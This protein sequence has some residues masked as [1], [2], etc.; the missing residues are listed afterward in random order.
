MD[1]LER[2]KELKQKGFYCS[3]IM[4]MMGLDLMGKTNPD[5]IRSMNSLAGG[6][7]FSGHVCGALTGGCCLLGLYAGK[8]V[9]EEPQKPE[10]DIMVQDLVKWFSDEY[11]P[12]YGGIL[13]RE[14]LDGNMQNSPSRCPNIVVSTFQKVKELLIEK[15]YDL[16]GIET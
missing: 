14:I 2:L 9:P 8:G 3:Q 6:L 4:L 16:T 5:L 1:D 12:L 11:T 13:C 15:G 7:G 10:L